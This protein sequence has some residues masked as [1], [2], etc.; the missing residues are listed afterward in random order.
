MASESGSIIWKILHQHQLPSQ[1]LPD[2]CNA[3]FE[4]VT[5]SPQCCGLICPEAKQDVFDYIE[6]FTIPS[7]G[8]A[9][10]MICRRSNTKSGISNGS[11]VSSRL[12]AIHRVTAALSNLESGQKISLGKIT[13]KIK[14]SP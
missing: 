12:V 2:L 14:L 9:S 5:K 10:A 1:G 7:A 8:T 6:M 11:R 4:L 3:S 13:K